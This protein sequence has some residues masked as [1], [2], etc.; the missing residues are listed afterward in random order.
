MNTK[1]FILVVNPKNIFHKINEMRISKGYAHDN[2]AHELDISQVAFTKLENNETKLSLERLL[3]IAKILDTPVSGLLNINTNIVYNQNN[4][5][6]AT[7][8]QQQIENMFQEN[9]ETYQE[10]INLLKQEIIHL[11]EQ[12]LRLMDLLSK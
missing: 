6:K 5:E 12:N 9:K 2:M 1:L 11:K 7:G 4:C 10:H 8:Y 3:P